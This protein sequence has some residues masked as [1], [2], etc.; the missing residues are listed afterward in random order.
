MGC[1]S[2]NKRTTFKEVDDIKQDDF[3]PPKLIH[4]NKQDDILKEVKSEFSSATN[5]ESIQRVLKYDGDVNLDGTIGKVAKYC[6]KKDFDK[7]FQLVKQ[8]ARKYLKNQIFWN[9][10]G[11]CYLLKNEKRKALLFFNKALSLNKN[12]A[13]AY[14]NMGVMYLMDKDYS[15]SLVA[16]K[17]AKK[18]KQFSRTPRLNLANLY[19][20]FGLHERAR[21]EISSLKDKSSKDVD[22]LNLSAT[23]YLMKG[24]YRSAINEFK[25]IDNDYTEQARIG[26]NFAMAYFLNGQVDEAKSTF[27][28]VEL[29]DSSV[30]NEYYAYV[31]TKI[32]V[33][34]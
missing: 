13:P 11:T 3:M 33:N 22:V 6:Y 28:D 19:I 17:R 1:A 14:N 21:T 26:L 27:N 20:S 31:Q 18:L 2:Q 12:Y 8:T 15:R 24:E 34:K 16:F 5:L 9:Q 32:G 30:W 29:R 25:K 7:A 23:A 10:V 4:Y